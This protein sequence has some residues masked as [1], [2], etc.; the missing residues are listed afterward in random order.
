MNFIDTHTHLYTEEYDDDRTAVVQRAIEAGAQTLL[1]PAIDE[2]TLPA[3]LALCREFPDVCRPMI[4]LHP[5]EL[6][7]PDDLI[8]TLDRMEA[9]LAENAAGYVAVG[10]CGLDFYWD[11]SRAEEQ[12][13]AFERQIAW[14]ERY[15]LPLMIHSRSAHRELVNTLIPHA[16]Q[17]CGG[18]FHCFSG[19]R[20]EAQ[21]L[22]QR[23]PQFRL[24]IGGVLT[25]KNCH[26]AETLEAVVPIERIVLETDAPYLAPVPHRG[27]RNESAYVPLII[28]RLSQIYSLTPQEVADITTRNAQSTFSL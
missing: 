3:M 26:L 17:I 4:G 6:P 24:G 23:F 21:E 8:A 5:T 10:E 25:F 1:L 9:L 27:T 11:R 13:V 20:E 14:A 2:A 19:S 18:V 22:L 12:Q 28:E 16:D 7:A 15:N